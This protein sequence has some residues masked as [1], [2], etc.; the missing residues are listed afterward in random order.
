MLL[1]SNGSA[2]V[3]G[4]TALPTAL[5]PCWCSWPQVLP[6]MCSSAFMRATFFVDCMQRNCCLAER[7]F[8]DGGCQLKATVAPSKLAG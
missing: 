4:A 7:M 8:D 6:Y 5:L 1:L 3:L 2:A